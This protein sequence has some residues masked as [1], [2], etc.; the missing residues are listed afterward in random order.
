[1][2][3]TVPSHYLSQC[4]NI[5]N[6]TNF[7]EISIQIHIFSFKKMHLK[8]SSGNQQSS[9]P[10]LNVL[11]HIEMNMTWLCTSSS[12][13][14]RYVDWISKHGSIILIYN[15]LDGTSP[16]AA[17]WS[18]FIGQVSGW[19]CY[20]DASSISSIIIAIITLENVFNCYGHIHRCAWHKWHI[21]DELS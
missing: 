8:M 3:W 14:K 4:W 18:L 7:S 1:M 20:D 19:I 12:N 2:A 11:K 5:V 15:D 16:H 10:G 21:F 17:K 6:W 13:L 9:C